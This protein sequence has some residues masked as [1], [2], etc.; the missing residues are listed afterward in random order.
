MTEQ[1]LDLWA[2]RR[3]EVVAL[4]EQLSPSEA[5][6]ALSHVVK[7][8]ADST[9]LAAVLIG[10]LRGIVE[11]RED[12]SQEERSTSS[13]NRARRRMENEGGSIHD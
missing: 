10:T 2:E 9:M 3:Q 7:D 13:E 4:V 11:R 8:A 6:E 1:P 12:E 5:L